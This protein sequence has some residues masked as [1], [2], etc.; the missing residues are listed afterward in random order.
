MRIMLIDDNGVA[1]EMLK[2]VIELNGYEC[3]SYNHSDEAL[4]DFRNKPYDVVITDFMMPNLNGIELLKEI[5]K[6]SPETI[7]IIYTALREEN[8][9]LEANAAGAYDFFYKPINWDSLAKVLSNIDE[10]LNP[11]MRLGL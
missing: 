9:E 2:D 8:I 3:K 5:K 6:I 11:K 10:R 7:V 1:L 4:E